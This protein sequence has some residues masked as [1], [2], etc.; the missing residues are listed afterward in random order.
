MSYQFIEVSSKEHLDKVFAFRYEILNER[1]ETRV[2][3]KDCKEERERDKYDDFSAHFV[4]FDEADEVV[5]YVRLI[6]HSPIGYPT[7]NNMEYDTVVWNF[8]QEQLGELSRVFVATRLRSIEKLKPLF[9]SLKVVVFTKMEDL[10]IDYTFG[11][12]EKPFFRLLRILHF[13]YKRIG[14]FQTYL[15]QRYPCIVNT[16]ELREANPKLFEDTTV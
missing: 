6:H 3:L 14:G 2:L 9:N 12:L 4:A 5:A 16:N 11:A 10:N 13:P 15:G 1:E 7:A 8:N